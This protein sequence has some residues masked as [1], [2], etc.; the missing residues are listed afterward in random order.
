MKIKRY[1]KFVNED[2]ST[3]ITISDEYKDIKTNIVEMIEKSVEKPSME[4]LKKTLTDYVADIDENP[5][6]GLVNDSDVYE[7]YLKW[8]ND[9]DNILADIEFYEKRPSSM[10]VFSL[11]DY[12]VVGTKNSV[13]EIC[14]KIIGDMGEE[15]EGGQE[16]SE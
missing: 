12:I 11:Y 7:F 13:K 16:S 15:S 9:I 8:R 1:T 3:D 4:V 10:D 14:S 5:I 2:L 6:E